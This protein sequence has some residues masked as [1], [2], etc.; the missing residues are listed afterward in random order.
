VQLSSPPAS[1]RVKAR[2]A[3]QWNYFRYAA[4]NPS[5]RWALTFLVVVG[6]VAQQVPDPPELVRVSL[7]TPA[8]VGLPVWLKI[9][10]DQ[11]PVPLK[12]STD[13]EINYPLSV[14]PNYHP[15]HDVEVRKDGKPFPRITYPDSAIQMPVTFGGNLRDVCSRLTELGDRQGTV[16]SPPVRR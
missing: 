11:V 2:T 10:T 13:Q 15:C 12:F 14:E 5:M 4:Y 7:E 6:A 8:K 9:S 1:W 3:R 16:E